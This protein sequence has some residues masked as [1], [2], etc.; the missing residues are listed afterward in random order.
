MVT[1]TRVNPS[2]EMFLLVRTSSVGRPRP[3]RAVEANP[4]RDANCH[5]QNILVA[6][7]SQGSRG[8]FRELMRERWLMGGYNTCC[9]FILDEPVVEEM[10]VDVQ[11]HGTAV[12]QG[13]SPRYSP[14]T[15]LMR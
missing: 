15:P 2:G 5:D 6:E 3:A 11:S 1:Y 14:T 13:R 9:G 7:R 12:I 8:E 10:I 4:R